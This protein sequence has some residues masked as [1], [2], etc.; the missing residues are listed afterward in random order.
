MWA[1]NAASYCPSRAGELPKQ[2]MTKSHERWDGKL[3]M[4]C[5]SFLPVQSSAVPRSAA[6][7]QVPGSCLEPWKISRCHCDG[8]YRRGERSSCGRRPET[9]FH[10]KEGYPIESGNS[11]KYPYISSIL[12]NNQEYNPSFRYCNS[13]SPFMN[14]CVSFIAHSFTDLT[15]PR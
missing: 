14:F 7:W 10:F 8:G 3:Q 6:R 13:I 1:P 5:S 4:I 2:N 12:G 15:Q 9:K 11:K